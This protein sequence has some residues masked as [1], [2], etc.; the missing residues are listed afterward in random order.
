[1]ALFTSIKEANGA[2][3]SFFGKTERV[4]DAH[5]Q[6]AVKIYRGIMKEDE[7]PNGIKRV[8]QDQEVKPDKKQAKLLRL[9]FE[10]QVKG[11][12]RQV[13]LPCVMSLQEMQEDIKDGIINHEVFKDYPGLISIWSERLL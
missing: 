4:T 5:R 9:L 3:S 8:L 12:F 6:L 13:G 7:I 11:Y 10:M 2:S 1:M